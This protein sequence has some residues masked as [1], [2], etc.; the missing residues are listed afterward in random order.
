M[1]SDAQSQGI[2]VQP[3]HLKKLDVNKDGLLDDRDVEELDNLFTDQGVLKDMDV[4]R[5][6]KLD[7]ENDEKRLE[8]IIEAQGKNRMPSKAKY[9]YSIR[10]DVE[11]IIA[12]IDNKKISKIAFMLGNPVEKSAGMFLHKKVGD[13]V[14][15]GEVMF[16]IHTNSETK[17]KFAI[18][19]IKED[20]PYMILY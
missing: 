6:G 18:E 7:L 2:N 3:K 8:E 16:D 9:I 14:K 10:S 1:I 17:L 13:K 19:H 5:N 15:K 12:E 20:S 11:G 4:N